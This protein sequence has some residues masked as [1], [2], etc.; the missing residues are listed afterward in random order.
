MRFHST[1]VRKYWL[2]VAGSALFDAILAFLIARL[3]SSYG[4]FWFFYISIFA[5]L[6]IW[7]ILYNI[8]S[9]IYNI[10]INIFNKR[11]QIEQL[12]REFSQNEL[13]HLDEMY[14][15]VDYFM[16]AVVQSDQSSEKAKIY[17]AATSAILFI[18]R[19]YSMV[20]AM[21]IRRTRCCRSCRWRC[22]NT[23]SRTTGTAK[24]AGGRGSISGSTSRSAGR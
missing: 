10:I 17:A 15:D 16:T 3:I 19:K 18:S 4:D 7:P 11:E 20:D 12:K 5:F 24:A 8:R 21:R 1:E 6:Q 14:G 13:P 22:R 2:T 9:G 23:G